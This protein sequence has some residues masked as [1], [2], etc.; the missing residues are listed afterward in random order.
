MSS[1]RTASRGGVNRR[2]ARSE[3]GGACGGAAAQPASRAATRTAGEARRTGF[4]PAAASRRVT[5]SHHKPRHVAC[6]VFAAAA[7][8]S[9]LAGVSAAVLT[10]VAVGG[11]AERGLDGLE[12]G[13]LLAQDEAARRGDGEVRSPGRIGLEAGP[14]RL[15][16]GERIE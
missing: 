10:R 15:V 5:P 16:G 3:S 14:V 4:S 11:D 2:S 8:G 9:A 13:A 6:G 7:G 12:E 1:L